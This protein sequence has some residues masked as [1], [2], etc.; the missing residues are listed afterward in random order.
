[1]NLQ[2]IQTK[3]LK[4]FNK[5]NRQIVFWYD[6]DTQFQED[7]LDIK[8]NLE[9]ENIKTHF[10]EDFNWIYT[11]YLLEFEDKDT[12]YLIYAPF[13]KPSDK[14]NNLADTIYYSQEFFADKVSFFM[15]ELNIPQEFK[16]LLEKYSKFFNSEARINAFKDF[17]IENYTEEEIIIAILAVLSNVIVPDFDQILKELLTEE[18]LKENKFIEEFKKMN[19]LNDFWKI[20]NKKYSYE[21]KK[22][23]LERFFIF[24]ILT[25]TSTQ[26]NGNI[27]KAWEKHIL[28]TKIN[29]KV[30]I[31]NLM[32]N[33][34]SKNKNYTYQEM[35]DKNAE[36]VATL[37]R[38]S[39]SKIHVDSIKNCDSFEIFDIK[40]IK[41]LADLLV[42]NQEYDPHISDLIETR[43]TTHFYKKFT[44]EYHVLKWANFILKKINLFIRE[45]KPNTA[46]E[47]IDKYSKEWFLIDKS[48][49]KFYFY[50]DKTN[51]G[52]KDL[53]DLIEKMYSNN[54]LSPLA[55]LWSDNYK[56]SN[57]SKNL[58][59]VIKQTD[60]YKKIVIPAINKHRTVVIISDALRYECADELKDILNNDENRNANLNPMISTVPSSTKFGMSALLPHKD[61]SYNNNIYIENIST[62]GLNNRQKILNNY[63]RESLAVDY[64]DLINMHYEDLKI[65]FKD[66]R[67]IYVYHNQIDARGDHTPSE[68]EVF[69][70]SDEGIIEI[71]NLIKRLSGYTNTTNFIVTADHGFIYRKDSL[72]ESDKIDLKENEILLKNKRYLLS[73]NE[74]NTNGTISNKINFLTNDLYVT[75]PKGMDIFKTPGSGLNYVHGGASLQEIIIPI[76]KLQTKNTKRES[77]Q[78]KLNLLAPI[79]RKITNLGTILTFAQSDK[80]SDKVLPL[81][82]LIYIEDEFNNKISNEIIIHANKTDDDPRQLEFREKITVRD[83]QYDKSKNYYLVIEDM[84]TNTEL[85][86][87]EFIIDLAFG[88]GFF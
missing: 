78:V 54:Y 73:N 75:V 61:L 67:L 30:F 8:T 57:D 31:S 23:T 79:N 42:S 35:Y 39:L 29:A 48:Y 7:I 51:N 22:P 43:V 4:L 13:S 5:E 71:E 16:P 40:I 60:F 36:K 83:K 3:L 46:D 55:I 15:E 21:E 10:L 52:F 72:N 2:K 1:M 41:H 59:K 37:F 81:Q 20:V 34:N 85:N 27:P 45:S 58:E 53:R 11:K 86:R 25:Y 6:E 24:L 62:E 84:D 19:I 63:S 68:N 32:S 77:S 76:I 69:N 33:S 17:N 26:F 64:N 9:K 80:I 70:A 56:D 87:Y 44:N 14:E 50:H 66:Y 82:A 74:L 65:F 28:K 18:N 49:R 47:I 38:S 12:N 88:D